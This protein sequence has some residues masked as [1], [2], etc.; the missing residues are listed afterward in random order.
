VGALARRD[1]VGVLC[2]RVQEDKDG[3]ERERPGLEGKKGGTTVKR[4]A[5][6]FR[7]GLRA[8]KA[9]GSGVL[10]GRLCASARETATILGRR[11]R[12]AT[13]RERK[14]TA[15]SLAPEHVRRTREREADRGREKRPSDQE[16]GQID[17]S[18]NL[19]WRI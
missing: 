5:S 10:A 2:L 19:I 1:V 15:L 7:F 8:G 9:R 4:V 11:R 3:R 13:P 6:P 18:R 17:F 14:E 16:G 12:E